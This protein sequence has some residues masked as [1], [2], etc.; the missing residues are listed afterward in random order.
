MPYSD[1]S[2]F[3]VVSYDKSYLVELIRHKTG[4]NQR[5]EVYGKA[6]LNY[7]DQY[8]ANIG[9]QS[10]TMVIEYEYI[11]RNYLED[12]SEYYAR[13][14]SSHPRSCARVHFFSFDFGED[15]FLNAIRSN[16][17]RFLKKLQQE[18]VGFA[19]LRP[20]PKTCIAKL[21]LKP[22]AGQSGG[23]NQFKVITK[24]IEVTLFGIKL[25]VESAPFLEQDK[26]VSACAT[27]AIWTFL[28]A[29]KDWPGNA[30]P[31]PSAITKS[32]FDAATDGVRTFPSTGLNA[33]Q[34]CRSL[35]YFDFEPT[36][37]TRDGSSNR[38]INRFVAEIKENVY[39]HLS[40]GVPLILGGDIYDIPI[41]GDKPLLLGK[42]LVC[43]LGF[44]IS[45][46]S[47]TANVHAHNIDKLY[48][49]D[50]RYGPYVRIKHIDAKELGE[51]FQNNRG[52]TSAEVVH[53]TTTDDVSCAGFELTI[54]TDGRPAKREIFM[55][56]VAVIGLYHKVRI[57][58]PIVFDMHKCFLAYLNT[59]IQSV[60]NIGALIKKSKNHSK[61]LNKFIRCATQYASGQLRISLI[62]NADYKEEVRRAK[63]FV[64]FNGIED[65]VAFLT[66]SLP[67]F[68]WQC[69]V[70]A[71]NALHSDILIDATEILQ[72]KVILGVISYSKDAEALFKYI[73]QVNCAHGWERGGSDGKK[74]LIGGY[75]SFF[76]RGPGTSL[77]N[78]IYGP[79]RLPKRKL[80]NGEYD[81]INNITRRSDVTTIVGAGGESF[82]NELIKY[83]ETHDANSNRHKKYIWVINSDGH[84]VVGEDIETAS[85]E[86]GETRFLG[87]PTLVNGMPA[88][89]G[90]EF[91]FLNG[92]WHI[93][94][95]SRAYPSGCKPHD[96][97]WHA[98]LD[99][100]IESNISKIIHISKEP[101]Q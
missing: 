94:L 70:Y 41:N 88:R 32:A 60:K 64:S 17:L 97:Q 4:W 59:T 22:Y 5:G 13:C 72:G 68:I 93:N 66:A 12:Y 35:K 8:L 99:R 90:G 86:T 101:L 84:L 24:K 85:E 36:L 33:I 46:E 31:S 28:S 92:E 58:Y 20:I 19:V 67:K 57:S 43:V 73:E 18:Y 9:S 15:Q 96:K 79:L 44:K 95:K 76:Q 98:I 30:N 1:I 82:W 6:Q 65:R 29:S 62:T 21:C 26:V 45:P 47:S 42:H 48:V 10:M 71:N 54:N 77:L 53:D 61:P 56:D 37:L 87:H 11:D 16:D 25:S 7:I 14:F 51:F 38:S 55:P 50:D 49:H 78:S 23:G 91:V 100:I 27:S 74:E 80:K 40:A 39:A 81:D 2:P 3:A 89:L 83:K 63:S 75:I 52:V 69:R 34:V